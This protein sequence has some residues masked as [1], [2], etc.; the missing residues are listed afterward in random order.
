[1]ERFHL[2]IVWFRATMVGMMEDRALLE[3]E[4][5]EAFGHPQPG[6]GVYLLLW[7]GE[8]LYVGKSLNVFHR[9]GQH[10]SGMRRHKKGLRPSKGKEEIPLIEFDQIKVK[11]VPIERLDA[12]EMKLIQRYLP[13]YNDLLK[14]T[15]IDVSNIPG[16]AKLIASAPRSISL[17]HG[18]TDGIVRRRAA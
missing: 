13:E 14:R 5:F 16:V 2:T 18:L 4:G 12:E 7:K 10:I 6:S 15:F 17:R 3:R 11:W 9:V 8:V 1:M